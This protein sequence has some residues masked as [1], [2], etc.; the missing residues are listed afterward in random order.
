[1]SSRE[2]AEWVAYANVEPFGDARANWHMAV[3]ALLLYNSNR[4]QDAKPLDAIDF[5]WKVAPPSPTKAQARREER[6]KAK[7]T[8]KQ[9]L[10]WA[11]R[12][13]ATRK[14]NNDHTG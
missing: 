2:I 10:G 3:L 5:M 8:E 13:G 6:R 9:L 11:I 4:A 12:N 7:E 14:A 1:M